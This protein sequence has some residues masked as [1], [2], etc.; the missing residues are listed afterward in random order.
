MS[1]QTDRLPVEELAQ[2]FRGEMIPLNN[3]FS[4]LSLT[5]LPE[6][7]L[8]QYLRDPVTA[9]PLKIVERLPK[10]RVVL[11][12][13]LERANGTRT[14]GGEIVTFEKPAE[15]R[16]T[17]WTRRADEEGVTLVFAIKDEQMADYH[18]SF[19]SAIASVV[20]ERQEDEPQERFLRLVREELAAEVH[21]EVDERSWHLKQAL[22]RRP[23]KSGR[24]SKQFREYARQAFLDTLTLYLHGLCC[25]IDV[26]TGPRQM[27]SRYLRRRLEM[28]ATAFPPPEGYAIFPETK[29]RSS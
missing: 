12:P 2:R 23:V 1:T 18:Y 17:F 16:Q 14:P 3:T 26:E 13:F 11:V 6:E 8:R 15:N 4:Y 24:E 19:Y 29:K 7:D 22:L 28:L 20:S 25:D 5:P 9:L 27:A 10:V 21:G